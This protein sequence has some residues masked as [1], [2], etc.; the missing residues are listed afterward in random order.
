VKTVEVLDIPGTPSLDR[1]EVF[2]RNYEPGRGSVTITC[3]GSA[4]TAYFGAMGEFTIQQFFSCA[5]TDY[6]VNKLGITPQLKQ[7]KTDHDY[8]A[9]IIDAVKSALVD[10]WSSGSDRATDTV[11]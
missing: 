4:W 5:G 10:E 2:W 1:I 8:L 7:R 3:Y 9:K 11:R 6:L